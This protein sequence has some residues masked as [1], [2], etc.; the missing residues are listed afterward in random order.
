[1]ECGDDQVCEDGECVDVWC[2][3]D[4]CEC[5]SN[6]DCPEGH[7]CVQNEC[8]PSP[9]S[10]ISIT[11]G[12]GTLTSENYRLRIYLAPQSPVGSG[13]STNYKIHLGPAAV[14]ILP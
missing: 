3:E 12:G 13:E 1:M 5:T 2:V 14:T 10:T 7:V 11:S 4:Q 8:V 9:P 6:A